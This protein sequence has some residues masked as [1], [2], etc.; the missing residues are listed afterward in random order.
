[1]KK[2]E[3]HDESYPEP[4]R[5]RLDNVQVPKLRGFFLVP[6]YLIFIWFLI[7]SI[8][9]WAEHGYPWNLKWG[10]SPDNASKYGDSFGWINSLFSGMAL[11]GVV[12]AIYLQMHELVAQRKELIITQWQLSRSAEAQSKME[13]AATRQANISANVAILESLNGIRQ[14]A[15]FLRENGNQTEKVAAHMNM[16]FCNALQL[17]LLNNLIT[18]S[19]NTDITALLSSR[20]QNWTTFTEVLNIIRNWDVLGGRV[21]D[22]EHQRVQMKIMPFVVKEAA[23][24]LLSDIDRERA[25]LESKCEVVGIDISNVIKARDGIAYSG[26]GS[27]QDLRQETFQPLISAIREC[28]SVILYHSK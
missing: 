7:G 25:S 14:H 3:N 19:H 15:L 9:W 1:M 13:D 11:V 26:E 5:A 2:T 23:E 8:P 27:L 6:V 10:L 28:L 18:S 4:L 17:K 16:E 20:I 22:Y 24:L 21:F 12:V